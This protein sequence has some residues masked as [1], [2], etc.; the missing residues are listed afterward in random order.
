MKRALLCLVLLAA[1][2]PLHAADGIAVIG[3][4]GTLGAGVDIGLPLNESWALRLNV[5]GASINDNVTESGI[6]YDVDA[7]GR[8]AGLLL[9][10]HPGGTLFRLSA[11]AYYNGNELT[12]TGRIVNGSIEINGKPYTSADVGSL[13][14]TVDF[15]KFAPY[16]GIGLGNVSRKG[17]K[18]TADF[19]ALYQHTPQVNMQVVCANPATC[20]TL[21]T[22]VAAESAQL[23]DE[24][25]NYKWW[26][27][28]AI[29]IGWSF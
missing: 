4:I 6:N 9:D 25:R 21:Q 8:T 17:F 7:K 16:V 29:G 5:N 28:V 20:A 10:W 2:A 14:S 26:P 15:R 22:D 13:T 19:G 12:A 23:Q 1:A 27:V 11:G 18:V 24:I 3:K